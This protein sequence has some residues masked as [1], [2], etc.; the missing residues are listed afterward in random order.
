MIVDPNSAEYRD[1]HQ[2]L[3][4]RQF[5]KRDEPI[6]ILRASG[7]DDIEVMRLAAQLA[8]EHLDPDA[9]MMRAHYRRMRA[10]ARAQQS[11]RGGRVVRLCPTCGKFEDPDC[12]DAFHKAVW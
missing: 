8:E 9:D 1:V 5:I 12:G 6:V 3:A 4:A 2:T 7:F 10:Y 11:H